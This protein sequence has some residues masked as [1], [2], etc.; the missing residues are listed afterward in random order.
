MIIPA[1]TSTSLTVKDHDHRDL[2]TAIKLLSGHECIRD[3]SHAQAMI[4]GLTESKHEEVAA[5]AQSIMQSALKYG[6]FEDTVPKYLDL[7]LLADKT[8]KRHDQPNSNQKLQILM[9][10]IGLALLMGGLIAFMLT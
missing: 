3:V 4:L 5:E 10:V 1:G 9:L 2:L 7:K 8:I 6:W